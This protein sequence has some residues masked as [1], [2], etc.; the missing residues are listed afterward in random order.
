MMKIYLKKKQTEIITI[1]AIIITIIMYSQYKNNRNNIYG[2][3]YC[4]NNYLLL[5]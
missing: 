2:P 5:H 4:Y 3:I 1:I